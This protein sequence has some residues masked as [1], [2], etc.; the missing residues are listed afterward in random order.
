[1]KR[2]KLSEQPN[3][4]HPLPIWLC[5]CVNQILTAEGDLYQWS[6]RVAGPSLFSVKSYDSKVYPQAR[7]LPVTV[8]L[9]SLVYVTRSLPI[10]ARIFAIASSV[11]HKQSDL[12]ASPCLIVFSPLPRIPSPDTYRIYLPRHVY[13]RKKAWK[14]CWDEDPGANRGPSLAGS[15]ESLGSPIK[16]DYIHN[17]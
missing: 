7:H 3:I 17:A 1:M 2:K 6:Y 5:Y 9:Y 13:L 8:L 16:M 14:S 15:R 10:H 12:P 4:F 11:K